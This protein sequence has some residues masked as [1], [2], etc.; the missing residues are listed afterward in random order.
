MPPT[1]LTPE[2]TSE[3]PSRRAMRDPEA[4]YRAIF[5]SAT[6]G[7]WVHDLVTG[8]V[9]DINPAAASMFG[10]T[11]Q[12]MLEAGHDAL[13]FP[14]TEYTP[15][16]VAEYMARTAA[17]ENQRFEWLGRHKDGS[18]VWSEVTLRKVTIGGQDRILV[19][20]R[21]I[22][23]RKA[24]ERALRQANEELERRVLER[25]AELAMSMDALRHS[26]E[27]F[28]ALIENGSDFIMIVDQTGAISYVGPS[29]ERILG[30]QPH[31][32][33]GATPERLVHPGDLP[34]VYDALS[35]VFG[36]PGKVV[37]TEFRIRH[38][39]GSWRIFESF[40]RTL[41]SN[42]PEGG[43]VANA[44]DIT[45]RRLAEDEIARQKTYFEEI[46]GS[47]EAGIAVFDKEGRFEY[48]S[49]SSIVEPHIRK[50]VVGKTIEDYG[51]A[52]GLPPEI[53]RER[54]D[55]IELAIATGVSNRFEQEL[56]EPDGT[57]RQMLRC[58][59]PLLNE[60]GEVMRLVGYSVDISDRKAAEIELKNAK[61][62]AERANRAKSDF[63][64]RMS[65]ELRTPLNAILG[66]AQVLE[67]KGLPS[68]QQA[69]LNHI[70]KGGKHLLRL[71]NEVL[72]LSRIEAGRMT[73]SLEPIA[74]DEVVHEALDLVRP[75]ATETEIDLIFERSVTDYGYVYADRQRLSQ[76]LLN[77]LSNGIKYNRAGGHV[78]IRAESRENAVS[79][80]VQDV[81]RGIPEER[82]DQLFTPFARLGAEQTETEGTGLGLA[83]SKRLA[84]AMGG[85]LVL[86]STGP[87]GSVFRL[88]L[89]LAADPLPAVLEGD[90]V[91][92]GAVNSVGPAATI[93]YIEDNLTNLSLIETILESKPNI[94][95]IS[96]LRGEAGIELAR[97]R[98]PDL[99]L[100]DL[101]LP[102]VPGAE[103]LRRLR[104]DPVTAAI[105]VVIIS[106]DATGTSQ[107]RL[108]AAGADQ[109]LTKP[110][111]L[112][113]FLST[114]D[115]FLTRSG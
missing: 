107:A 62:E 17:G 58:I 82:L 98:L 3:A 63:L 18:E 93:L 50:W 2:P 64:S 61:E 102:D 65:H 66:F 40:G 29:V 94:T 87:E 72:E 106:A 77:L 112:D 55:A 49:A 76:V 81:G 25:T 78:R 11:R 12:E 32:V 44:R 37:E 114:I 54:R 48:A 79:I 19:N 24:A 51:R 100:L 53:V 103:V 1:P 56:I 16:K 95:T 101:H 68:D 45:E 39:N 23:E 34:A 43:A 99:I 111:D 69:H 83:L 41:R 22:N 91:G 31:E 28:R 27:H 85:G 92:A 36:N 9:I 97:T 71:I 74:I 110:L 15:E 5:E 104:E 47:L 80:R 109:Y 7:I 10:Y 113:E 70:I 75:L 42:G 88:D 89:S 46:I 14:G 4:S 26:E 59:V 86:E 108:R 60:A 67:R 33:L 115:H 30:Y 38:R 57:V 20:S 35:Q 90:H 84:E 6:D 8:D 13:I 105:P 21:G 96:A 73:L 52:R